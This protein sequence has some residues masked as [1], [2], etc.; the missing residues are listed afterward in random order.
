MFFLCG[1]PVCLCHFTPCRAAQLSR[2]TTDGLQDKWKNS[3]AAFIYSFK[4]NIFLQHCIIIFFLFFFPLLCFCH[5]WDFTAGAGCLWM[6]AWSLFSFL[7]MCAI[8]RSQVTMSRLCM[9]AVRPDRAVE[10]FYSLPGFIIL[11][12]CQWPISWMD[13]KD[14]HTPS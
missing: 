13:Y 8:I 14:G 5:Q 10:M 6:F 4:K 3:C 1:T 11:L 12:Y 9:S 7:L 2:N